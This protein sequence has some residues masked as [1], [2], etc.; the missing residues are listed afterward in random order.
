MLQFKKVKT[1][2]LYYIK[3]NGGDKANLKWIASC[4]NREDK[5]KAK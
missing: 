5:H 1:F 2:W 4:S 3:A